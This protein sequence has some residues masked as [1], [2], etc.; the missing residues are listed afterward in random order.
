M[1][2]IISALFLLTLTT[3]TATELKELKSYQA[4]FTQ[5]ITDQDD[6]KVVY[7]GIFKAKKPL[8]ALWVYKTPI[9]KKLYIN[10]RQIVLVEPELEQAIYRQS[11]ESFTLFNLLDHA[12]QIGPNKYAKVIN[13]RVYVLEVEKENIKNITYVDDFDNDVIIVFDNQKPNIA[14]KAKEFHPIIPDDFD[15]LHE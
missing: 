9:E 8:R 11:E 1:I 6:V 15:I 4:N 5:T 10:S 12:K 3:L 14:L 2:R 7:T 13:Q